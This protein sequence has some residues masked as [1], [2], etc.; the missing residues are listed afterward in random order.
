MELSFTKFPSSKQMMLLFIRLRPTLERQV[1]LFACLGG[2][3]CY[4][5]YS[6]CALPVVILF[7]L[8]H[9]GDCSD[10]QCILGAVIGVCCLP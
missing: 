6:Q 1:R 9:I 10:W 2:R 4:C 7:L 3:L 8:V 5:D